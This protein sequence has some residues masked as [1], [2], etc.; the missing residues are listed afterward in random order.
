MVA[1]KLEI[2]ILKYK[3]FEII[4]FFIDKNFKQTLPDLQRFDF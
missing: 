4:Y 3:Y 1:I 2:D